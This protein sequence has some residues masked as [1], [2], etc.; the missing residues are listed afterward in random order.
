MHSGTIQ[1]ETSSTEEQACAARIVVLACA[2]ILKTP[3]IES[4]LRSLRAVR[5]RI[6]AQ[7]FL[8]ALAVGLLAAGGALVLVGAWRRWQ[9]AVEPW[10]EK[11][12]LIAGLVTC[13]AACLWTMV[14]VPA[15]ERVA[16][17]LDR[18]GGTRDRFL[19]AL[20]FSQEESAPGLR[21][22]A[23][24]ECTSFIE[25]T[26]F[27]S[28]ARLRR[29]SRL[30]WLVVP[31]IALALLQWEARMTFEQRRLRTAAARE[32]VEDSARQLEELARKTEQ[33]N[34]DGKSEELRKLAEEMRQRAE[35]LR[36][37][38]K[39]PADAEKAALREIS[40]LEKLV[41]EMQKQPAASQEMQELAK[42]LRQNEK[43]RAAAEAMQ[44]GDLAKAA[45]ELEK[46]LRELAASKDERTPEAVK[47]ALE[48]ALKHLAERQKL[49]DQ[50]QQLSQQMKQGA[51]GGKAM[52]KLAEALRKMG[53][54]KEQKI[55]PSPGGR[56]LTEQEMKA[57]LAALQ[58]MKAGEGQEA[59]QGKG[60]QGQGLATMESFGPPNGDKPG[61]QGDPLKPSGKPGSENDKG[62][63]DAPFGEANEAGK[64]ANAQQLAGR[65]GEGETL[66]QFLP[67]AGD[68][69]RS[70]R[71]YKDLYQAM[72]PAAEDAVLQ[73]NIPLGSRF[74]IKRYFESIR[75]KE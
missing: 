28:H 52:Q 36:A 64:K 58:N 46:S 65:L 60:E 8:D 41:R 73:E 5:R 62:T 71:R 56:P 11:L 54:G 72:A 70:N 13:G 45:E 63:T 25:R 22:L 47:Q 26:D 24:R 67:S 32:A 21:T 31:V 4:V 34:E 10:D 19:T 40:E 7:A 2:A 1:T 69:S 75:P 14:R 20:D 15:L 49:S 44:G 17:W 9:L 50:M 18:A 37:E 38:A 53:G 68:A 51:D 33:T 48:D 39:D 12:A 59:P 30:G 6:V 57:L 61:Q 35:R 43:T 66:Q 42:A 3:P 27:S 74:F 23:V 55:P 29:P 16:R